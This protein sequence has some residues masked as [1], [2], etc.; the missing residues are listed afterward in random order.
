MSQGAVLTA[1]VNQT[2]GVSLI[3]SGDDDR[4]F[5]SAVWLGPAQ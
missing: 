4:T 1:E 5:F 2:S 3:L